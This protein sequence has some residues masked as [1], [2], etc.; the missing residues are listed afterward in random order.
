V[1]RERK[2]E[3]EDEPDRVGEVESEVGGAAVSRRGLQ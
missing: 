2:E 1:K 3:K